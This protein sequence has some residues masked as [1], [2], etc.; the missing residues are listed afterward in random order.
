MDDGG[1]MSSNSHPPLEGGAKFSSE[2]FGEGTGAAERSPPRKIRTRIFRPSLKGRVTALAVCTVML[3]AAAELPITEQR[4]AECIQE[5]MSAA[6]G[7][8]KIEVGTLEDA[9][10]VHP[11]IRYSFSA[12]GKIY[13]AAF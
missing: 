13:D 2:N 4:A 11:L 7:I 9:A 12:D 10:G 1:L 6:V 8:E 5:N 3:G